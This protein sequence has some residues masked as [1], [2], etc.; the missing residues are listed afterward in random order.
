MV[1][2]EEESRILLICRIGLQKR[3]ILRIPYN[4]IWA[5]HVKNV[6]SPFISGG[7]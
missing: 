3:S 2:A 7:I 1:K 5:L 4:F 6:S